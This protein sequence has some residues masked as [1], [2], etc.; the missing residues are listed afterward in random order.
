MSDQGRPVGATG[1]VWLHQPRALPWARLGSARWAWGMCSEAALCLR[2]PQRGTA[3]SAQ[4][5][6]LGNRRQNHAIVPKGRPYPSLSDERRLVSL[7]RPNLFCSA[8]ETQGVALG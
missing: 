1:I 8:P 5:N 2:P 3:I 6:A 4:G 7:G